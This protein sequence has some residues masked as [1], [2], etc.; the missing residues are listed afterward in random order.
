ML[1]PNRNQGVSVHLP[2]WAD[3]VG[4]ASREPRVL[5]S[6][7]TGYPRFFVAR[8]VHRLAMR[9]L[10]IRHLREGHPLKSEQ[11]DVETICGELAMVLDTPRHARMCRSVLTEWRAALNGGTA[12]V[13]IGVY[14]VTWDGNITPVD[15][16]NI[17]DH[18]EPP[19]RIDDEDIILVS[20]PAEL[21]LDA[22]AFWQHTGSGIS[23]RRATHWLENAPFLSSTPPV[24]KPLPPPAEAV[25]RLEQAKEQLK[26]RIATGQS[27]DTLAVS[28]SDVFLFPTGMSAIAETTAAIKTLRQPTPSSAYRVAVFGYAP[29][30]SF[31]STV[32]H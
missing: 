16:E 7:K 14:T 15:Q 30:P 32:T 29:S 3:T 20:Y 8:V 24:P 6:M 18:D 21:A 9:L 25:E 5:D 1:Y 13:D 4:W 22:K 23:S 28:P 10:G 26:Y 12:G 31:S 2:K 19:R 17:H 27:S 11:S